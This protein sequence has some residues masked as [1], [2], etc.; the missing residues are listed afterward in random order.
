MSRARLQVLNADDGY[1]KDYRGGTSWSSMGTGSTTVD[2]MGSRDITEA[3]TPIT[4]FAVGRRF[5]SCCRQRLKRAC[6]SAGHSSGTL[7][8]QTNRIRCKTLEDQ[9]MPASLWRLT[10]L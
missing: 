10:R 3:R 4:S 1:S 6:T 2:S 7:H 5:G 9:L 8:H